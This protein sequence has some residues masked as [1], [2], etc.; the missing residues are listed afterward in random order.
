MDNIT[1]GSLGILAAILTAP[2]E[3]RRKAAL[4][5]FIA[6]EL[7]D[8]DSF[9]FSPG[10]PLFTLQI[11]RHFTHSLIFIPVLAVLGVL[12]ANGFR[13]LCRRPAHWRGLWLPAFAAAATHGLCDTWT[14]Y[15]THLL[16]PFTDRRESWDMISVID[17]LFTLP[18]LVCA[19]IAWIR[20]TRR[21]AWIACGWAAFY[22]SLCL[23]QQHRAAAAVQ[24]W[25]ASQHHQPQRLTVKPS[26]GNILVWRGLY[27]QDGKCQVVCVRP[28]LTEST[29]VLGTASAPLLNPDSPAPPLTALPPQSVQMND[30]RRFQH[31]SDDWLGVHPTEPLVIGDLRYA[32]LPDRIS[33]LWGI[34]LDPAQ[35]DRHVKLAYFRRA[36]DQSWGELWRMIT[37]AEE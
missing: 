26:F 23:V 29:R 30:V 16:W 9:L 28:G 32:T 35:P 6:A 7:P 22:L 18:V 12:L 31:F 2:P 20:G 11:H 5:G 1:H 15:G 13:K 27:V 8:L 24:E 25:A 10:D 14:S 21:P 4:A 37:G 33:P 34:A 3:L 17:P 19:V 36:N